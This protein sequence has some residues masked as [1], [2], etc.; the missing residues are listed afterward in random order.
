LKSPPLP[1]PQPPSFLLTN[2]VV[3]YN[4]CRKL[5]LLI[6]YNKIVKKKTVYYGNKIA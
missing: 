6:V 3:K 5:I 4:V 2:R 1:P